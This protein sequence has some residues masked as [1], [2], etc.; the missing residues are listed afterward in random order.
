MAEQKMS[1]S[2]QT[3]AWLYGAGSLL[4]SY[5]MLE[6]GRMARIAAERARVRAEFI[7]WQADRQAGRVLAIAQRRAIEERRVGDIA[8][9]RALAVAAASGGGVSDPTVVK[10]LADTKGEAFYRASVALY[11]GEAE[12]RQ[13]RLEAQARRLEGSE[14]IVEGL[15]QQQYAGIAAAGTLFKGGASLYAKYG[16][17]G[18]GK[19]ESRGDSELIR[20]RTNG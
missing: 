10:L 7:A 19:G 1:K 2:M 15:R 3:T 13:L 14:S 20:D 16:I 11:E 17:P 6:R 18:P 4:E 5:G 12:A 8:A 9:S